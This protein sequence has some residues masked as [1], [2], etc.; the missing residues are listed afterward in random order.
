[1]CSNRRSPRVLGQETT[2]R[3]RKRKTDLQAPV[4]ASH[5]LKFHSP[6]YIKTL[7]KTQS[8]DHL[9]KTRLGFDGIASGKWSSINKPRK[10]SRMLS[11][12]ENTH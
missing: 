7:S 3:R 1:M 10:L 9:H 6:P 11:A 2:M 4:V 8:Q 5:G 12:F